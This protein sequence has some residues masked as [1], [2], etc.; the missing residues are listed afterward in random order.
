M[1]AQ[2]VRSSQPFKK[3]VDPVNIFLN[4]WGVLVYGFLFLPIVILKLPNLIGDV[5]RIGFSINAWLAAFN[6]LPFWNLDGTKVLAW[7]PKAFWP[8]IIAGVLLVFCSFYF[9]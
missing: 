1:S 8:T 9:F 6:M 2:P 3:R 5:A 4:V 7:N